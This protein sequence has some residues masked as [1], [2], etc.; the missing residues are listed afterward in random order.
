MT[1]ADRLECLETDSKTYDNLICEKNDISKHRLKK[2]LF[3]D[4]EVIT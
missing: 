1:G 2:W 4:V 3:N